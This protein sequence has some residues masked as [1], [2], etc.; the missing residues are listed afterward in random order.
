MFFIFVP[1][2]LYFVLDRSS[3]R[4]GLNDEQVQQRLEKVRAKNVWVNGPR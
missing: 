1:N 4:E 3:T 2:A